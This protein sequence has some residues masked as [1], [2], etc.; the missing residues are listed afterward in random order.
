VFPHSENIVDG[1]PF[2]TL[3]MAYANSRLALHKRVNKL[4]Q[5]VGWFATTASDGAFITGAHFVIPC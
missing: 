3:D 2:V 4:E 5:V 1:K